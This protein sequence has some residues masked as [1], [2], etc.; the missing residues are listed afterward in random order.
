VEFQ[1]LFNSLLGLVSIFVGW[2]LRAVWD[3]VSNLQKDVTALERHMPST[4]VRRDDYQLDITEIKS[5]LIRIDDK[6]DDKVDKQ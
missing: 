1:T 4:Y 3:A 6:L 5:M 2:Y